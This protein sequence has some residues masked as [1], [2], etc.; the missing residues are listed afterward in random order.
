MPWLLCFFGD[1]ER[2]TQQQKNVSLNFPFWPSSPP[3]FY[4]RHR[5][6]NAATEKRFS[7][8]SFLTIFTALSLHAL[9]KDKRGN[10]KMF[11]S[12]FF[13][14][15]FTALFLQAVS[16]DKRGNRK[17]FLSIFLFDHLH[18]P[19]FTGGI[20]RQTRQEKNV[21]FNFPFCSSSPPRFYRRYRKTNAATE[22]CF[23]QFSFWFIFTALFLQVVS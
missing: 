2:Q 21:S 23:F 12:I 7:Q 6:T 18:R 4:R 1:A 22:K 9:S 13:L 15:I 19:I 11:L 5:K 17:T 10:R 3:R 8:F 20:E 16:K 14:F